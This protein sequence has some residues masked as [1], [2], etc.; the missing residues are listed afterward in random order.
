MTACGAVVEVGVWGIRLVG[1]GG[2][3]RRSVAEGVGAI[4]TVP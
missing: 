3:A 4:R 1:R 2:G